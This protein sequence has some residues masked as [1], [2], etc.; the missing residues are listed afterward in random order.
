VGGVQSHPFIYD[1]IRIS[2]K[3]SDTLSFTHASKKGGRQK[4]RSE[5]TWWLQ[6]E[7]K[8]QKRTEHASSSFLLCREKVEKSKNG[9][10]RGKMYRLE[11]GTLEK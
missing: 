3:V 7:G 11:Q 8:G 4:G 2:T 5:Q 10:G 6:A 1:R 9:K